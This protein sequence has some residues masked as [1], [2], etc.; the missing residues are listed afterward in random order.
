MDQPKPLYRQ[1]SS[2]LPPPP[3]PLRLPTQSRI[4]SLPSA[5]P[6]LTGPKKA[7]H[8]VLLRIAVTGSALAIYI[9]FYLG[10]IFH[11]QAGA[12]VLGRYTPAYT[13]N[14]VLI[15]LFI[16]PYTKLWLFLSSETRIEREGKEPLIIPRRSKLKFAAAAII[17]A[18]ITTEL[19]FW[20][21]ELRRGPRD[22]AKYH[23]FLQLQ[24]R[25]DRASLHTNPQGFR[26]EPIN[27]EK[28]PGTQRLFVVGGSTVY[29]GRTDFE[30]T[31]VRLLEEQIRAD[32][33]NLPLEVQNCGVEW[34]TTQH[35]LINYL[36]NL[37]DYKPDVIVLFHAIND[38][39]RS[40]SPPA[41]AWGE[42][43]RD[44]GHFYGPVARYVLG[45]TPRLGDTPHPLFVGALFDELLY[46]EL[47]SP[48]PSEIHEFPSLEP[49]ERNLESIIKTLKQD[50]V[51]LVLAT[52]ASIYRDDLE[53]EAQAKLWMCSQL[54]V[55]DN[56]YP[57]I[58]SMR[59]AMHRFNE[60]T[61]RLATRY[62]IPLADLANI[63]PQDLAHF[64]DDVH[65]TDA[66]N[67]LVAAEIHRVIQ[68]Q[69]IFDS[70]NH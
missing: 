21:R 57:D 24:G 50:G 12:P 46:S 62:K 59:Q 66:G 15:A 33:P 53:P 8:R 41:W 55:T 68:E 7:R 51:E 38:L 17:L 47:L 42:P 67:A 22:W 2:T 63:V 52:Q 61:R 3:I 70:R 20:Y 58:K 23:P 18:L 35:S 28:T 48:K 16:W 4:Q 65:L 27:L 29:C 64:Y 44:Y 69:K 9:F 1:A 39:C 32:H 60:V 13:L 37:K 5:P 11:T 19:V 43:R 49:F 14:L 10:L 56:R 54:C 25:A 30:K 34:Y 6:S 31:H 45:R 40:F 36:F 26:G